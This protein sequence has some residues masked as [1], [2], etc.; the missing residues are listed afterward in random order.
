MINPFK[1]ILS[2]CSTIL[3]VLF[4][5]WF[6]ISSFKLGFYASETPMLSSIVRFLLDERNSDESKTDSFFTTTLQKLGFEI[7]EDEELKDLNK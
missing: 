1:T 5:G 6:G 3:T 7:S 4:L 2:W